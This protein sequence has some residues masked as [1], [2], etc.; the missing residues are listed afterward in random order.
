MSYTEFLNDCVDTRELELLDIR[1][2]HLDTYVKLPLHHRDPFDRL[3]I[4]QAQVEGLPLLS[5]D[6]RFSDYDIETIW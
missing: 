6:C 3:L 5:S 4:A 2:T 1:S